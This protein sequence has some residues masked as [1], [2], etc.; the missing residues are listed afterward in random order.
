M[1]LNRGETS[2]SDE[3]LRLF[4]E[5]WA[6]EALSYRALSQGHGVEGEILEILDDIILDRA[7]GLR[8][9][10]HESADETLKGLVPDLDNA[11]TDILIKRAGRNPSY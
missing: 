11:I 8:S 1:T 4:I 9:Q 10:L 2:G 3:T 7:P 5:P 6:Y